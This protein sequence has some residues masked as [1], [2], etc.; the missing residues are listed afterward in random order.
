MLKENFISEKYKGTITKEQ[1]QNLKEQIQ[2]SLPVAVLGCGSFKD[3]LHLCAPCFCSDDDAQN[4]TAEYQ[5]VK[6]LQFTF[7]VMRC[8]FWACL[9]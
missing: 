8:S 1:G 5:R 7:W 9:S 6:I 2:N 3:Q 4:T